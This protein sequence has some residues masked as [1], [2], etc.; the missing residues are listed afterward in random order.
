MKGARS[1][2]TMQFFEHKT[3]GRVVG[4]EINPRF[5]GGFPLSYEAKANYPA[6]LI[7]EYLLNESLDFFD[8]WIDGLVML[9]YDA[10]VFVKSDA[11]AE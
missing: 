8:N 11:F 6:M 2:L 4:I 5:G 1:C 9:R 3:S 10:E 7:R